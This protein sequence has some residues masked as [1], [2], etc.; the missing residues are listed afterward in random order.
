[1]KIAMIG[2][3]NVG[4]SSVLN[5]LTGSR[6]IISN[7]SGTSVELTKAKINIVKQ[8][9]TLYDTPGIYSLYTRGEEQRVIKDLLTSGQIGM[10]LN[11]V[12]ATNIERNLVLTLE[13]MEI[14]IPMVLVLNQIDRARE[15]GIN[16]D[17]NQ[18]KRLLNTP[19]VSFSATTGEGLVQLI[20]ILEEMGSAGKRLF[21]CKS[22]ICSGSCQS[23]SL[24]TR[25]FTDEEDVQRSR[26][27][28]YIAN[29]VTNQGKK[30]NREVLGALQN[31]IDRPIIGIFFLLVF[32]YACFWILLK[33]IEFSEGP[34]V[35]LLEPIVQYMEVILIN[36]LPPGLVSQVLSRAVPEGLIIPFSIIMPAM[37]MVNF[38]MSLLE[39]T[40]LLPRYS[41]ALER[42]GSF[43]GVSGQAIIPL[44]LG[45]GCRTP[46]ILATR[47]MPT[48]GE[49]FIIIT[50]LSIVVPCAATLGILASVVS[51]FQASILI[52]VVTML[53][54][55]MGL[56][57]LLSRIMPR[58][59]L[60]IYELPPL[61]IPMWSNVWAKIKLRFSGFFTE[62]L[63]LLILMNII[64][65]GLIESGLL[66]HLG[67]LQVITRSLFG[68]P[69]EAFVAVIIT[70]FQ[71][72]LAPL[73]LLNLPLNPREATVAVTMVA[74]SLPC[75][76]VMVVTIKEIGIQGLIKILALGFIT[77][78][79]VG[80]VLNGILP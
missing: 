59:D 77:S 14:G 22:P 63:P 5:R 45:F 75:L 24:A 17:L 38:L 53:A 42:V 67:S 78:F 73:V 4:K 44:T 36:I 69:A 39:D 13:L 35:S 10:I 66:E 60:F 57:F 32:A 71:R 2:N 25:N 70:I 61:R 6:T 16:I 31:L 21:L 37:L 18:L 43:L 48:P 30:R 74:L 8:D 51:T 3:P 62:V 80:I 76:P 47:I 50:M 19:V 68:I 7:Y 28:R 34:V 20:R 1:V 11:I 40:G 79:G 54:V 29:M 55:L 52:I 41:V 58:E 64:I 72:Y 15:M 65:R 27:A 46:A 56:G 49:R 23:C 9:I 33:F 12:D 26:R